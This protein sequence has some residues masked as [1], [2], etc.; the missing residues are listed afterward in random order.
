[1]MHTSK[2]MKILSTYT[3]S[4]TSKT[5]DNKVP[6]FIFSENELARALRQYATPLHLH[7]AQLGEQVRPDRAYLLITEKGNDYLFRSALTGARNRYTGG[8]R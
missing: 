1:M 8:E 6:C 7:T 4:K 2:P 5:G 3:K